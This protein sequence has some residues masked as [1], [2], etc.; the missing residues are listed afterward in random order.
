MR[1]LNGKSYLVSSI[2]A[3]DSTLT[4]MEPCY[5]YT[6][7]ND[8]AAQDLDRWLTTYVHWSDKCTSWTQC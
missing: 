4:W 3:M 2:Y 1:T 8:A 7:G 6:H 5:F